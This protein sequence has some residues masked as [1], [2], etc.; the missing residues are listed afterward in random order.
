MSQAPVNQTLGI[1]CPKCGCRHCPEDKALPVA[2]TFSLSHKS[3]IR[4]VRN[5]RYCG[6]R[7]STYERVATEFDGVDPAVDQE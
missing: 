6:H 3:S 2:Q 1:R 5:C 7:F 4:R